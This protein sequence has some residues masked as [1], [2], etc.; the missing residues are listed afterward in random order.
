MEDSE[1]RTAAVTGGASGM[2]RALVERMAAEGM[3][4]VVADTEE[5]ALDA[6]VDR[7]TSFGRP[8]IGVRTDVS[9]LAD[10]EALA[11]AAT[12]AFGAIHVLCA[13]AGV[14]VGGR[15]EELTADEWEW[16]IGVDVWAVIHAVR[17]FLPLIERQCDG[18]LVATSSASGLAAPAFIAPYGVAKAGVI[19]LME[20][21][22][23]E[24]D[25]RQSPIGAS[26]LCPGMVNTRLTESERNRPP[27]L[28]GRSNT[29]EGCKFSELAGAGLSEQGR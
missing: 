29:E 22:R 28:S 19:A 12:K 21:L 20:T 6:V 27:G 3:N 24:L 7:L 1:G 5:R 16:V 2:G 17:V 18:H 11:D 13:N 8:A 4:V 14:M 25:A 26:V 9:Q 10:L 23:R 15:I